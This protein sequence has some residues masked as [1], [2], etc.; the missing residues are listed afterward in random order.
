MKSKQVSNADLMRL[1]L[2]AIAAYTARCARRAQPCYFVQ[3]GHCDSSRNIAAVDAAIRVAEQ[4]ASGMLVDG[5]EAKTRGGNRRRSDSRFWAGL[6]RM[7][8]ERQRRR[9]RETPDDVDDALC[10]LR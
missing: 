10:G 2:R 8:W 7:G 9:H 4:F 6:C 3:S 1:P 5:S